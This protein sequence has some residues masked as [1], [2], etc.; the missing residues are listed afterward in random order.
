MRP[1]VRSALLAC[2]LSIAVPATAAAHEPSGTAAVKGGIPV[3][4]RGCFLTAAFVPRPESVLQSVF[5]DPLDI[6]TTFYGPDPLLGI[7]A[8]SCDGSRVGGRRGGK[9]VLSLVGVPL[10]LTNA[11]ALPFANNFAH[12]LIRIDTSSRRL[13][14]AAPPA[15]PPPQ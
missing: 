10:G 4:L 6:D 1:A 13:A 3:R 8:M 7:W 5:R 2:V 11:D 9:L 14:T 15:G 12:R